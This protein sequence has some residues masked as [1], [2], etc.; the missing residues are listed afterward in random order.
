[1]RTMTRR[2]WLAIS[3][4]AATAIAATGPA[5]GAA[6]NRLAGLTSW[7]TLASVPGMS[8]ASV[9]RSGVIVA[10]AEGFAKAGTLA[11]TPDTLFEAASLSKS[12]LAVA[13]HDLV[14]AGVIDLDRPVIR[15][16]AFTEDPASRAVTPRHLLSHSSGLPN[17]RTDA[18]EPLVSAFAPGSR[19][20]YSGEGFVLLGRLVEAVTGQPAARIVG[21][22]VFG[23]AGMVR[24]T[25]GWPADH[26][27]AVAWAHDGSGAVLPDQGPAGFARRRDAG[28]A[29][30]VQDWTDAERV[31]AA[32]ASGKP[33]LPIYMT[34][35]MAAGLWTT[36][37]D[38]AR[39]LRFARGFPVLGMPAVV[40]R[41]GSVLGS[42]LGSRRNGGPAVRLALGEQRRRGE[43]VPAGSGDGRRARGSCQWRCGTEGLRAGG[44][45]GLRAGVRCV[46]LAMRSAAAGRSGIGDPS[47]S[48]ALIPCESGRTRTSGTGC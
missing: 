14:R 10:R 35:N 4:A 19:F 18:G 5:R 44:P 29:K 7:M 12:V 24:S 21:A 40:V 33:G 42:G 3:G 1:M 26:A 32:V 37:G 46:H 43:P 22:R 9:D 13:V 16:V 31:A 23:P 45:D 6:V 34:P 38:Y 8:W 47:M 30:P 11:A 36:A 48:P 41:G 25:Y 27:P 28:P 39:F 20:R 17:W 15:D 2:G